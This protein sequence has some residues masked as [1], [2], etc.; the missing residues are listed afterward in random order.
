VIE[1]IA[2]VTG[3]EIAVLAALLGAM[4]AEEGP[5]DRR[6]VAGATR[7]LQTPCSRA[8]L[9]AEPQP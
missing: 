7:S 4:A 9:R 8:R 5:R 2:A 3:V 1:A 6:A